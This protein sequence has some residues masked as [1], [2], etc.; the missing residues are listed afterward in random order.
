MQQQQRQ[1]K[2]EIVIIK[3]KLEELEMDQLWQ[4]IDHIRDT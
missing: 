1:L 3:V 4:K 2:T